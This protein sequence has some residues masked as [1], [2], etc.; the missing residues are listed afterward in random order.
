MK[1][2][3]TMLCHH[4]PVPCRAARGLVIC[5]TLTLC[6]LA[7]AS[8]CWRAAPSLDRFPDGHACPCG[9]P[10]ACSAQLQVTCKQQGI[11]RGEGEQDG[12]SACR[13]ALPLGNLQYCRCPLL[14][15]VELECGKPLGSSGQCWPLRWSAHLSRKIEHLPLPGCLGGVGC[16]SPRAQPACRT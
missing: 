7:R 8:H 1:V 15:C 9:S 6:Q 11:W 12:F 10:A 16:A 5:W 2:T 13:P 14:D 3:V 4:L